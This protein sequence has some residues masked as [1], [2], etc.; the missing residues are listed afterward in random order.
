MCRGRC[1]HH[2]HELIDGSS[3]IRWGHGVRPPASCWLKRNVN[4]QTCRGRTRTE[5]DAVTDRLGQSVDLGSFT[6]RVEGPDQTT[7]VASTD[8][9][10]ATDGPVAPGPDGVT[11]TDRDG[12]TFTV[13]VDEVRRLGPNLVGELTV[14][15]VKGDGR[16]CRSRRSREV[17]ASQGLVGSGTVPVSTA[18]H[19]LRTLLGWPRCDWR[20]WVTIR[21][22]HRGANPE[23]YTTGRTPGP[24]VSSHC[25]ACL[26]SPG[27]SHGT[28]SRGDS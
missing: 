16:R 15:S 26:G 25:A 18:R 5:D 11:I 19:P 6:V 22:R 23:Q 4:C 7:V 17:S 12:Q 20:R 28:P 21:E 24:Q 9:M 10:P 13:S 27:I 14:E 8:N 3:D 1:H 2:G